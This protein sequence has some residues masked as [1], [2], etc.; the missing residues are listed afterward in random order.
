MENYFKLQYKRN[1]RMLSDFG[2]NPWLTY[3]FGAIFFVVF[4]KMLFIKF[5]WAR[6]FFPVMALF[7]VF[8]IGTLERNDF[9][10]NSFTKN[11]YQQI[12]LLENGL[13][14]LPFVLFEFFEHDFLLGV[15]TLLVAILLSFFN[16]KHQSGFVL[17]TPF[18]KNPFEFIIGF[19]KSYFLFLGLYV[20]TYISISVGNFNLGVF[21]LVVLFLICMAYYTFMEPLFYVWVNSFSIFNF[22]KNKITVGLAY[23]FL[24]SLPVLIALLIAFSENWHIVLILEIVGLAYVLMGLVAKYAYYPSE[25]TLIPAIMVAFSIFAPPLMLA[26]IP[27]FYFKS[28]N[29]LLLYK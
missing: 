7:F 11:K 12:R 27:Y 13:I 26:T 6:Y 5:T 21:A 8:N 23:S 10:K 9:L 22:L 17:P 15:L 19:R 25:L 20:L 2:L 14:V 4:S 3:I 28:K 29:N 24:L 18:F 16:T 1:Y